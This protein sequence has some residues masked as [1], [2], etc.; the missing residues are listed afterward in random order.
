MNAGRKHL[1]TCK[2]VWD[3]VSW[4]WAGMF[5][6]FSPFCFSPSLFSS[7]FLLLLFF[8]VL[9]SSPDVPAAGFCPS[10]S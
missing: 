1:P 3:V 7:F 6:F 10:P 4:L 2:R 9:V 8:A 5:F